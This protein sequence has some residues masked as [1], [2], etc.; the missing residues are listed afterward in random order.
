MAAVEHEGVSKHHGRRGSGRH[1]M[2]LADMDLESAG[3]GTNKGEP[4]CR[5]QPAPAT[6]PE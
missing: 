1:N 3:K 2:A 5:R 6:L 4:W